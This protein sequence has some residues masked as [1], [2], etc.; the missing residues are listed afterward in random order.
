MADISSSNPNSSRKIVLACAA[1]GKYGAY[2]IRVDNQIVKEATIRVWSDSSK[3]L[4]QRTLEVLNQAL[5]EA[6]SIVRHE[7]QLLIVLENQH[8]VAWLKEEKEY[9]GYP[10][11]PDIFERIDNL[12][13]KVAY[14]VDTLELIQE[15]FSSNVDTSSELGSLEALVMED[16]EN[17]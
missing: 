12:D 8:L 14:H 3:M 15:L 2:R 9:N 17:E 4:K 10:L 1:K 13:C 16:L 5:L 6:Q 11:L 7:D